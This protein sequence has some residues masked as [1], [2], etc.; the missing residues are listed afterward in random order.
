M[1][2]HVIYLALA[3]LILSLISSS[4]TTAQSNPSSDTAQPAAALVREPPPLAKTEAPEQTT[5]DQATSQRIT[6]YTLPPDRAKKAHDIN[7]IYFRYLLISFCY[8]LIVLWLILRSKTAARYRNWAESVSSRRII[9][10]LVFSPALILT[11]DILQLPT[12]I[13]YHWLSSSY[14]LSIQG[15]PSW[16]WDWTK[17]ELVTIIVATV[18]VWMETGSCYREPGNRC[19]M[20]QIWIRALLASDLQGPANDRQEENLKGGARSNHSNSYTEPR[21]G[22]AANSRGVVD[23]GF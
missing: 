12:G 22:R 19:A 1:K 20:V 21:L 13:Y 23:A 3:A 11:I 16:F 10:G 8:G 5:P 18:L 17:A 4:I 14:G 6:A 7:R 15:W 2:K 9:Q